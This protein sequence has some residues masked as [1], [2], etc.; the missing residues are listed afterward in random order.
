MNIGLN[1]R[2]IRICGWDRQIFMFFGLNMFNMFDRKFLLIYAIDLR[3]RMVLDKKMHFLIELNRW[4]L[5]SVCSTILNTLK[6]S[7]TIQ[8][9]LINFNCDAQVIMSLFLFLLTLDQSMYV[10]TYASLNNF[11][12]CINILKVIFMQHMGVV[13]LNIYA[14]F[15]HRY[16]LN[17]CFCLYFA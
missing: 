9:S 12:Y 16:S 6:N 10:Q 13:G 3:F 2:I 4:V 8:L 7:H 14:Q 5:K 17:T 15:M 11:W 1:L